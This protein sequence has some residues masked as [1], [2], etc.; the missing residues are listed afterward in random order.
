M[1]KTKIEWCNYTI[2]PVKGMCPA[3]CKD[4][5]GKSYCYARQLYKR[6][7]WN[8]EIRFDEDEVL[9]P[10]LLRKAS[11]IFVGSTIELFGDWV[12]DEW[13]RGIFYMC[14]KTPRHTF[15]FLTRQPQN[16]MKWSPFPENCWVGMTVTKDGIG[17]DSAGAIPCF[18]DI[19]ARVKFISFEPLLE[20]IR[21]DCYTD[22][23]N[24]VIIG[25]QTQPVRHPKIEWVE[26]IIEA[27]DKA[28]IPIFVKEP[29]ALYYGINRKEM[30]K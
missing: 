19:E 13:L 18:E 24:W 10:M 20:R 9:T 23:V 21:F 12:R 29:L 15:I 16:L 22:F 3:D 1:N 11:H 28:G 26:E 5:Q 25:S 30:P 6:F 7:K 8:P 2:N 27:G 14:E 17:Q 4:N